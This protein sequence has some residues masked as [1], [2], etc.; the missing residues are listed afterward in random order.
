MYHTSRIDC[1]DTFAVGCSRSS[2]FLAVFTVGVGVSCTSWRSDS[3]GSSVLLGMD[4]RVCFAAATTILRRVR[5]SGLAPSP[6]SR[7]A[8]WTTAWR[9]LSPC[10]RRKPTQARTA[11]TH[12]RLSVTLC[13]NQYVVCTLLSH[14]SGIMVSGTVSASRGLTPHLQLV[15]VNRNEWLNMMEDFIVPSMGLRA[16]AWLGA[17]H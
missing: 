12:R 4:G 1:E 11:K 13:F 14:S 2:M 9:R 10:P 17:H 6:R 3:V 16:W 7:T 8:C 15:K 5:A